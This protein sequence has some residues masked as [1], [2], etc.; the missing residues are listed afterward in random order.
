MLS[1]GLRPSQGIKSC[2]CNASA[3]H[4]PVVDNYSIL[5]PNHPYE[6]PFTTNCR[7]RN[8]C[9]VISVNRDLNEAD[10]ENSI[11]RN[12]VGDKDSTNILNLPYRQRLNKESAQSDNNSSHPNSVGCNECVEHFFR[13]IRD[14]KLSLG[15]LDPSYSENFDR[16]SSLSSHKKAS[17]RPELAPL[18]ISINVVDPDNNNLIVCMCSTADEERDRDQVDKEQ[19]TYRELIGR[20]ENE[21][22]E[23]EKGNFENRICNRCQNI[24]NTQPV[25]H[26]G[27]LISQRLTMANNI[28]VN[29]IDSQFLSTSSVGGGNDNRNNKNFEPY[30]PDS[31]ESHS[32]MLTVDGI[33]MQSSSSSSSFTAT[34]TRTTATKNSSV[35]ESIAASKGSEDSDMNMDLIERDIDRNAADQRSKHASNHRGVSQAIPRRSVEVESSEGKNSSK[36]NKN[37]ATINDLSSTGVNANQLKSRLERLQILNRMPRHANR[38]K[39]LDVRDEFQNE[40]RRREEKKASARDSLLC[41]GQSSKGQGMDR[42]S[43]C[44]LM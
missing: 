3:V 38:K 23:V 31:M 11:C 30:T 8:D 9:R 15:S 19:R 41:C 16:K 32:P 25:Q 37:G 14:L 44:A 24:I 39:Y 27:K 33:G 13:I 2:N 12:R 21:A 40:M 26:R 42:S 1:F 4:D 28:I 20:D 35:C 43:Q 17:K 29:R 6:H 22:R 10:K 5:N 7:S 36:L 18:A 34:T